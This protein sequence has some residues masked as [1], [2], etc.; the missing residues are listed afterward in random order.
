MMFARRA[1]LSKIKKP[2]IL[3]TR[4]KGKKSL[5]KKQLASGAIRAV[6][7]M[8]MNSS[9]NSLLKNRGNRQ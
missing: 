4:M 9:M 6:I 1:L 3:A 2:R 5:G 7:V 8:G